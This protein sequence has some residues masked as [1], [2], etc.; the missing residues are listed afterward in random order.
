MTEFFQILLDGLT[1]GTVYAALALALS[2]VFQGT[3][4]LN[5]A[6]GE[7]AVVAAFIAYTV[8]LGGI[9]P[10]LAILIAVA[11]S[12][13]IGALLHVVVVRWVDTRNEG[14]LMAMGVALLLGI[15]AL[16]SIIW[17]TDPRSFPSPFGSGIIQFAGLRLTYQQAGGALL[18]IVAMAL[19]ALLFQKTPIGLRLRAVAQNAPSAA[20]LGLSAPVWLALGWAVAG[21]VGAVAGVVAAPTLGLSPQ[22]MNFPLLMA[23]SAATLG[24][25]TS[26]VGAV[27][28]GLLIGVVTAFAGRYIPFLGGDLNIVVAFVLIVIVLL[29]KPGGLFGRERMVRA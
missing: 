28:G 11:A 10:W 9:P 27:V 15:S 2:V 7:L 21:A 6:Q 20:L 12:A 5:F 23:L 29:I 18:V 4:M 13:V 14:V 8:L 17:G 24:G 1:T 26:R 16:A 19:T 22:M 25:L 3:G